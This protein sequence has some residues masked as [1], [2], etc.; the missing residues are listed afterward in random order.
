MHSSVSPSPGFEGLS[1]SLMNRSSSYSFY[2]GKVRDCLRSGDLLLLVASDRLSAFDRAV[3]S[4]A[5]KG[6]LLTA[7]NSF[8][9]RQAERLVPTSYID[10]PHPRVMRVWACQPLKVEVIVRGYLAGSMLR[11]YQTGERVFC[12]ERLVDGLSPYQALPQ[13]IITPTSKAEVYAHDENTTAAK[14]IR[15]GVV[16]SGQWEQISTYAHALFDLGTRLYRDCGWILADTKYE[17]GLDS[18]GRVV[19]IDEL[20]T[21]D[22]SRLWR[23]CSYQEL[24]AEGKAPQ[25]FDKELVRGYLLDQ[26]FS[27]EGNVPQLPDELV[28]RLVLAYQQVYKGLSGEEIPLDR[29]TAE[30]SEEFLLGLC[31]QSE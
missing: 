30:L 18:E 21:P 4:V 3:G 8:W 1:L 5:H 17:F 20:H 13:P 19:L 9:M 22:S 25:M 16:S 28:S 24:L 31:D 27:G 15:E 26:G 23:L 11:A 14:L 6:R 2:R 10:T 12:G 7:I 29:S